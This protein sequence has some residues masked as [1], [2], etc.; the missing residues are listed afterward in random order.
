MLFW[1][2]NFH[3]FTFL[4]IICTYRKCTYEVGWY[5]SSIYTQD[6][7]IMDLDYWI[8]EVDIVSVVWWFGRFNS[9]RCNYGLLN[10][11]FPFCN[12][13]CNNRFKIK[14]Y[15][16]ILIICCGQIHQKWVNVEQFTLLLHV[17]FWLIKHSLVVK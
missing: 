5:I 4:L 17:S 1:R 12:I 7:A 13:L 6:V 8:R 9:C 2:I 3:S 16:T 10:I 14:M 15:R 11:K